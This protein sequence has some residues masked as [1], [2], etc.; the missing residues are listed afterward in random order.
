MLPSWVT[1]FFPPHVPLTPPLLS[2][3]CQGWATWDVSAARSLATLGSKAHILYVL[4]MGLQKSLLLSS[5]SQLKVGR[6]SWQLDSTRTELTEQPGI[7]VCARPQAQPQPHAR[8]PRPQ[9]LL[10]PESLITAQLQKGTWLIP[11]VSVEVSRFISQSRN[12]HFPFWS[13]PTG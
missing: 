6:G 11:I 9:P 12:V 10:Q 3:K 13:F 5:L 8:S 4:H 2:P 1:M 7:Q